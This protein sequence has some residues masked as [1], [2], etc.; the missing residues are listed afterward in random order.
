LFPLFF[1]QINETKV[2]RQ[3][4]CSPGSHHANISSLSF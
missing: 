3:R 2:G 1:Q 4:T